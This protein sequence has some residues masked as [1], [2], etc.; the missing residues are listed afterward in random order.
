MRIIWKVCRKDEDGKY[1]SC[2][3]GY[4]GSEFRAEYI[5][6]RA[7]TYRDNSYGFAFD[8]KWA[9]I[10]WADIGVGVND[11]VVLRCEGHGLKKA[12]T[13]I[14]WPEELGSLFESFWS[15]Q[16]EMGGNYAPLHTVLAKEI[17]PLEEVWS[18]D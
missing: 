17:V 10:Q 2:Y 16:E 5:P 15:G 6:G 9:A 13:H 12:P 11:F 1:W 8:T 14:L 18:P 4:D 7:T 3:A